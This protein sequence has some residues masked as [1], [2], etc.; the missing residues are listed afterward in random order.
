MDFLKPFPKYLAAGTPLERPNLPPHDPYASARAQLER[1]GKHVRDL[2]ALESAIKREDT[3]F[4]VV[5]LDPETGDGVHK[6]CG[7]FVP[8]EASAILWDAVS[9]LRDALDHA[10]AAALAAS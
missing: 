8:W 2:E 5:D 9:D 1:A 3:Y 7:F 6:F 4:D 10:Y